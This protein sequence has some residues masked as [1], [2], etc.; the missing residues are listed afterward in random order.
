MIHAKCGVSQPVEKHRKAVEKGD[1]ST[2]FWRII[3][4]FTSVWGTIGMSHTQSKRQTFGTGLGL[5]SKRSTAKVGSETSRDRDV[6]FCFS[7]LKR[8]WGNS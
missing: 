3:R 8:P 1:K 7:D 5:E 6:L 4:H 2:K